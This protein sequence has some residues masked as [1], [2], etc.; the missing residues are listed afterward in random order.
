[1]NPRTLIFSG[2]ALGDWAR[3]LIR[4]GDRLIGADR[5][6][7]YLVEH[8]Y[9]PDLAIGDFDSVSAAELAAIRAAARETADCDP[10]DKDYTD[11][12]LAVRRALQERPRELVLVGALGTRLDHSLANLHLLELARRSGVEASIV[13]A[14]NRVR[15]VTQQLQL[16]RS[17]Y[18]HV[19]LL[20][21]SE[22]VAGITLE[23]FRYPLREAELA[24]GQSL[25]ISNV[26][27]GERG[28]IAVRA[29]LLLV[30]E[31]HD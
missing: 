20:P 9:A 31:T 8:G 23:G 15:L 17:A 3:A 2:G 24:L 25:G 16:E 22:R 11:T 5:G 21:L 6:A 30:I 28:S 29:G 27:E 7:R 26:L 1:M 18:T 4:P 12:E 19:S 13:D 14:H 10:V